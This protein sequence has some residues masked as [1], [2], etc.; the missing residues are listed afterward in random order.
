MSPAGDD[1]AIAERVLAN[2]RGEF[3]DEALETLDM[4]DAQIEGDA[5]WD[6][7]AMMRAT[8]SLKG[9]AGTYGFSTISLIAHLLE[10]AIQKSADAADH[11]PRG[12]TRRIREILESGRDPD[13]ESAQAI[14]N[15]LTRE[16]ENRARGVI[17]VVTPS[18]TTSGMCADVA[19]SAGFHS[20]VSRSAFEAMAIA[21]Q[22]QP[23][24]IVAAWHLSVMT[25][26]E[27]AGAMARI[28]RLAHVPM[29][30][31]T[32]AGAG[33]ST[34]VKIDGRAAPVVTLGRHF[35]D[36][37]IAQLDAAAVRASRGEAESL[38]TT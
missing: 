36:D 27:M 37:L 26:V 33:A 10:T 7:E 23:V 17:V 38:R 24:A 6:A 2:L 11:R 1:D 4:L 19:E 14:I 16:T 28:E 25:A 3:I 30:I 15:T 5:P 13:P 35:A 20:L 31:V 29:V 21:A 34:D 9:Q 18:V 32:G 12:Y 22:A 8:H